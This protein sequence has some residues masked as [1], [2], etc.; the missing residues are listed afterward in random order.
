[1]RR[2][3]MVYTIDNIIDN[4]VVIE[5]ETGNIENKDISLFNLPIAEGDIVLL[6]NGKYIV[7]EEKTNIEKQEILD[8][9]KDIT[10]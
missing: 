1:M 3:T 4:I 2:N 6:N 7:D 10:S 5:D 9:L 8:L